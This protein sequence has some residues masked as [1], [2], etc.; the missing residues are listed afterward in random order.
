MERIKLARGISGIPLGLGKTKAVE[1]PSIARDADRCRVIS[2]AAR[3]EKGKPPRAVLIAASRYARGNTSH[4]NP[5]FE[6]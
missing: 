3:L 6:R 5:S 1:C 2:H 4:R